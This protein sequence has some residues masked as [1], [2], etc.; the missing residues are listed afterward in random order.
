MQN[1]LLKPK[2]IHVEQ[3]SGLR[4]RVTGVELRSDLVAFCNA[5]GIDLSRAIAR[6]MAKNALKYPVELIRGRH[7]L[8]REGS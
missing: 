3:L 5:A 2:N 1:N 8:E 6:K 7:S 4:A